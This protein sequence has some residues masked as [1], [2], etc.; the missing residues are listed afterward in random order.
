[1]ETLIETLIDIPHPAS[2]IPH[3]ASRIPHPGIISLIKVQIIKL[4]ICFG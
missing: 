3:P 4:S 1:M 2:R